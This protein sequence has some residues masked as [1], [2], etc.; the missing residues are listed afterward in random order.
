MEGVLPPLGARAPDLSL[1]HLQVWTLNFLPLQ[2]FGFWKLAF[3]LPWVSNSQQ[4]LEG[5]QGQGWVSGGSVISPPS[6]LDAGEVDT[7]LGV[8]VRDPCSE[9]PPATEGLSTLITVIILQLLNA[10]MFTYFP[11]NNTVHH[12]QSQTS[13]RRSFCQA[14]AGCAGRAGTTTI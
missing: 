5:K 3:P 8:S 6:L 14:G 1:K 7:H 13:L 10:D 9:L 12:K 11:I 2:A 4:C